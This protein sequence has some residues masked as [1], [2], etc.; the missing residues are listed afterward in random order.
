M[1]TL[2]WS[3]KVFS[4]LTNP[5]SFTTFLTFVKS[6]PHASFTWC[7]RACNVSM[8]ACVRAREAR[9]RMR[10]RGVRVV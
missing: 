7:V 9:A 1:H 4:E 5:T 8:C 6:P 3:M 10:A 2:G